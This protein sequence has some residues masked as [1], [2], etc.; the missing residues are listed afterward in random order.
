MFLGTLIRNA[1]LE[2][3]LA[4]RRWLVPMIVLWA[5][6][7]PVVQWLTPGQTD[8]MPITPLSFCMAYWAALSAFLVAARL[9][10]PTG[11]ILIGLGAVSYSV[12]LF[13]TLCIEVMFHL[14]R[15]SD[16]WRDV[17]FAVGA[18]AA[19]IAVATAVYILVERPAMAIGRRAMPAKG[20]PR[21]VSTGIRSHANPAGRPHTVL[22]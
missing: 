11:R 6:A 4:A 12:Y 18:M 10:R 9:N 16:P 21:S 1:W 7:V 19:T 5:V 2:Q 3:N 13:H 15:P 20:G 22:D 8:I 17:T 14:V